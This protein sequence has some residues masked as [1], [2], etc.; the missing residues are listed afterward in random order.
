MTKYVKIILIFSLTI[1]FSCTENKNK[2]KQIYSREVINYLYETVYYSESEDQKNDILTKWKISPKIIILGFPNK[3]QN[4]IVNN[5]IKEINNLNLPIKYSLTR[6]ETKANIQIYFDKNNKF[7]SLFYQ[8]NKT[9]V[10][11]CGISKIESING[12]IE[13]A[14]V[15]ISEIKNRSSTFK[16]VDEKYLLYEEILQTLGLSADSYSYPD[17]V[18]YQGMTTNKYFTNTDKYMLKL[19]YEPLIPAGYQRKEFEKDFGDV[20]NSINTSEKIKKYI[21]KNKIS[22]DILDIIAKTCFINNTFYKHPS[23]INL[24]LE[25]EYEPSDSIQVLK[26]IESLNEIKNIKLK[27]TAHKKNLT[28]S[29]IL[30][31]FKKNKEQN[32]NAIATTSTHIGSKT[33]L[34]NRYRVE[35]EILYSENSK[36][37]NR[38]K[39]LI[40]ES[41]YRCLGPDITKLNDL[42][43]ENKNKININNKYKLV[44]ST[45]YSNEFANSYKLTDF[46]KLLVELHE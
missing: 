5:V 45:I 29:G 39:G 18:F 27:F 22:T 44:L 46:E 24:Y 30:L 12:I 23:S 35:I 14:S 17:S 2:L 4:E 13:N 9:S 28:D 37:R 7:K 15:Y 25:G 8:N 34:L 41:L 19:L 11:D 1:M 40:M 20:L 38:K 43:T 6:D 21:L 32:I 3:Y 16:N 36:S 31:S 42:Y 26:S 33:M 10:N